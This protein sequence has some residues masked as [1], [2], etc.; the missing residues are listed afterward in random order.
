MQ[1]SFALED[2]EIFNNVLPWRMVTQE[3]KDGVKDVPRNS[4]KL[5]QE[6]VT[7]I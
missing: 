6:K 3:T 7:T 1:T 5:L 4:A 2:P